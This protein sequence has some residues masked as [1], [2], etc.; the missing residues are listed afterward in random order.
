[1]RRQAAVTAVPSAPG[2]KRVEV[3]CKNPEC[4][5]HRRQQFMTKD[6]LCRNRECRWKLSSGVVAQTAPFIPRQASA[7]MAMQLA[8]GERLREHKAEP[9]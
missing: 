8:L 6:G 9:F 7:E 1:M 4:K 3:R 2:E 5:F